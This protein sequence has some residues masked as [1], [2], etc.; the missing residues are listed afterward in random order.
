[1]VRGPG[2]K[3]RPDSGVCV[4]TQSSLFPPDSADLAAVCI[5]YHAGSQGGPMASVFILKEY[6][7]RRAPFYSAFRCPHPI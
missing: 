5:V 7:M 4:Y 3:E 6:D 2:L 1:M